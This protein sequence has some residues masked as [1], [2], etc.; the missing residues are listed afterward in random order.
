MKRLFPVFLALLLVLGVFA[1]WAKDADLAGTWYS[2]NPK[3]LRT[4]LENYLQNAAPEKIEGDILGVIAP[5]AGFRYSGP[6]AA[7]SYKALMDKDPKKVIVVGFTHRKYYT[8]RIAVLNEERFTTPLGHIYINKELT[9][10]LLAYN[11]NIQSIPQAFVS[12]NSLEMQVPFIQVA[13]KD[14]QIV[15]IAIADQRKDNADM[16]ADALSEVLKDEDDFVIIAS[17]DMC[18]QQKY[19]IAKKKDATTIE[20][21]KTFDPVKFYSKSMRDKNDERMCGFGAVYSVMKA[22][23]KLGADKIKVL[24]YANSGDTSGKKDSVVGY[25]SAVFLKSEA[26]PKT[27]E[28]LKKEDT[29]MFNQE[30][31]DKLLKIARETITHYLKTGKRLDVE[32]EDDLLK[33]DMGAFVTL[34]KKGQLRGCIG[35]MVATGPLYITVRDMAIA[36]AV[37]DPRFRPMTAAELDD[38]DI[39]ISA[40][41]PMRKIEDQGE[42]E[43]PKHGVMVKM[44]W[45]S[46]V[47][48]PQVAE[49]TGWSKEQF[50]DSLCGQKAGI[51]SD[52]WKTGACELYIFTAE[53]FG[54]KN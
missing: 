42:I 31:K 44:G 28:N 47:Y 12:E 8:N 9:K 4:E 51:P 2:G 10:R 36:A 1:A 11:N 7:Y 37:Q 54:E 19:E 53:V 38:I 27:V 46:G 21:I 13:F 40:L 35:H 25:M 26:G 22:S 6:I 49:E 52:A 34:H 33:Q 24:K 16:L 23:K 29:A 43:I 48:L 5:H 14:A 17:A 45:K 20:A 3:A 32:V 41:S 15:L 30:Q 50:M 39:E 18:H